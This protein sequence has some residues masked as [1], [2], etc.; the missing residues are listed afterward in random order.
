MLVLEILGLRLIAPYVGVTLQTNSAVIGVALAGIATGAWLGGQAADLVNPRVVLG[1]LVLTAGVLSLLTL[2]LVR[3]AGE[4]IGEAGSAPASTVVVLAVL[5]V[6]APAL[7]L[8]AVTPMVVKLQLGDLRRT[9]EVV[10][11]LSGLGTVGAIM[12]TFVTGFVLVAALPSTAIVLGL[13]GLLVLGG[14]G[15]ALL[16]A[17][18]RP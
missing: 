8:S 1:P 15:L 7:L 3:Y 9:G 2:P 18:G 10:G 16:L 5:A 6:F 13:G 4:A 14:A 17:T 12:A 11:K